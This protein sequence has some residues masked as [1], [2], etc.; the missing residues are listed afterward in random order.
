[1]IAGCVVL[2]PIALTGLLPVIKR[3]KLASFVRGELNTRGRPKS[4]RFDV[5]QLWATIFGAR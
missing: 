1:M 2:I 4:G 3:S 5:P